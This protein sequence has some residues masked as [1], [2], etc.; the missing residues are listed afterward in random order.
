LTV[1]GIIYLNE[2]AKDN[3][4]SADQQNVQNETNSTIGNTPPD[5]DD[6]NK[7][8]NYDKM[9]AEDKRSIRSYQKRI[10]EHQQKLEEF[11]NNPTV[12]PGM[13]NQPTHV[14]EKQQQARIDHLLKE[15]KTFEENISKIN[16]Q[17]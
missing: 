3:A 2:T 15:I 9:S 13:E 1:A 7:T 6:K 8:S 17:Y 11:K 14:I 10:R 12:R 5:D 16:N 4:G